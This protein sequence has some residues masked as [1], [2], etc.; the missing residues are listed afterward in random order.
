M[1]LSKLNDCIYTTSSTINI[2]NI[3]QRL[4][5]TI[6]WSKHRLTLRFNTL[7]IIGLK[8]PV[9]LSNRSYLKYFICQRTTYVINGTD[10]YLKNIYIYIPIHIY[11][12][13]GTL[14]NV[15]DFIRLLVVVVVFLQS[16]PND[17]FISSYIAYKIQIDVLTIFDI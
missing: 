3:V 15:H 2:I 1:T 8:S 12:V 16:Y 5:R 17:V 10:M 7:C 14:E 11:I 9:C 6:Q 13:H 4:H